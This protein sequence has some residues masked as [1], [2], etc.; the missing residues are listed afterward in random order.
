MSQ[1]YPK[2]GHRSLRSL[3][4]PTLDAF[5]ETLRGGDWLVAGLTRG[6]E[7]RVVGSIAQLEEAPQ[8]TPEFLVESPLADDESPE[9]RDDSR[10]L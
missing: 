7:P 9:C 2:R 1:A 8:L 3:V 6:V 10:M 5:Y 4:D